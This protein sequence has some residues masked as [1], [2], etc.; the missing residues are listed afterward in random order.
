MIMIY[1]RSSGR[2]K[3]QSNSEQCGIALFFYYAIIYN[4]GKFILKKVIFCSIIKKD[5]IFR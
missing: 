3:K 4:F 2:I 5:Y 1:I